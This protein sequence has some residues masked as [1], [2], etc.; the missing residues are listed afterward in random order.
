MK[1]IKT[2]ESYNL[3][4]LDLG[5]FGYRI[6]KS[7]LNLNS[8]GTYDYD[9][10][11]DFSV[12]NIKSLD[13]IPIRFRNVYGSFSCAYNN[14]KNLIGSPKEVNGFYCADNG[15]I[16]LEG[17]SAIVN[18]NFHCVENN[19]ISLQYSPLICKGDFSCDRNN[20]L[21]AYHK[22]KGFYSFFYSNLKEPFEITEQVIETVKQMTFEQ[23]MKELD[24]FKENDEKAF[25]RMKEVLDGLGIFYGEESKNMR[26]LAVEK[27]IKHLGF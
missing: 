7:L 9:G 10:D 17:V 11:L 1:I 21:S 2:Y 4:D 20:L 14:L 12:L 22:T 8:D 18:G 3:D 16:T 5:R 13:E 19:F 25:E 6:K 27:D 15:L 23:Q 24:Y 26:R